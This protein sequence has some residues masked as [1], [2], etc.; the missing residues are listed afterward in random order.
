MANSNGMKALKPIGIIVFAVVV[1]GFVRWA[2]VTNGAR[3]PQE[4]AAV[5]HS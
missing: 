1:I 3:N 5:K 4:T 2:I